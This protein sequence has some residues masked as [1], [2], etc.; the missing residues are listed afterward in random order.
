MSLLRHNLR[1]FQRK[2]T[3]LMESAEQREELGYATRLTSTADGS[4]ELFE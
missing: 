2:K 1:H 3:E 4:R